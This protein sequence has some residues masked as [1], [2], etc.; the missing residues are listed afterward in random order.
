M[1]LTASG[2]FRAQLAAMGWNYSRIIGPKDMLS[3]GPARKTSKSGD[4]ESPGFALHCR[5][6]GFTL[7][8]ECA[9]VAKGEAPAGRNG[10]GRV[11]FHTNCGRSGRD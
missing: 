8:P 5:Q 3:S 1:N 9:R 11:K 7:C 4:Q 10:A 6:F 2:T